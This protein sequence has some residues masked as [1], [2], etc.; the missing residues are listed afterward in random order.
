MGDTVLTSPN[1]LISA[2][3][4]L[5]ASALFER[6]VDLAP[7]QRDALLGEEQLEPA[8][9]EL[10]RKMF[11]AD[12]RVDDPFATPAVVWAAQL[13]LD[14]DAVDGLIGQ[15]IGGFRILSRLGQG[16]S[17]VVFA[18]ERDVAGAQQQ[19]A[20][21]LLQT[22]L[23]SAHAQRRFRRE[24]TILV[25]LTHPNIAHLIDAGVS[26]AGIPYIAMERIDGQTLIK[27]ARAHRLDLPSR[28]RLV[29]TAALAVDAAHRALVVHRDLKPDNILVDSEGRVKVLDFGIA[30]LIDD[31]EDP[32]QNPH[33][34]LTPGYA[35]PEQYRSGPLTTSVDVYALGVIAAE[36]AIDARLGPDASLPS[37]A[38]DATRRRWRALEADLATV[39]RT[40]LAEQPSQRYASAR[41]FAD[42]IERYLAREPIAAH[43]PSRTYRVRKFVSRHRVGLAVTAVMMLMLLGT[44]WSVL[45]QRN[46]AQQQAARADSMRDFMF[47]TFAEAEPSVPRD[48]P[49]TV[50]DAVRRAIA[51]NAEPEA[52]PA[53]RLELRLRLAQVLQRQG[54][55]DGA[56]AVFEAVRNAARERWGAGH[57][58]ALQAATLMVENSMARGEFALARSQLDG[59]PTTED[60]RH[61][62]ERLSLSAVLA[63]R[64]RELD[65]ALRDGEAALVL[66]RQIGDPELVRV[67]LNDWGVVLIAALRV[68]DAIKTYQELLTLNRARFGERHV[69]VGNVQAALS[70][71]YRRS[72]DLDRALVAARAA[73]EIDR[74]VYPGDDRHA[75]VNLNALMLVLRERGDLDEA[76]VVAREALRIN[77]AVLGDTHPDTSLARY[78]IGDLLMLRE[79][80]AQA[81]PLLGQSLAD[82][83]RAFGAQHWRTAAARAHYGFALGMSGSTDAGMAAMEQAI[84]DMQLLATADPD[85]LCSAIER[86]ARL[87]AHTGHHASALQWLDRLQASDTDAPPT[88]ACWLGNVELRRAAVALD[89]GRLIEANAAL[90]RAGAMIERVA[91]EVPM[92]AAEHAVLG[93]LLLQR[94]DPSAAIAA[95]SHAEVLLAKLRTIPP[96]L[97]DRVSAMR[98]VANMASPHKS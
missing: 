4:L 2:E 47:D 24:Q 55:L 74:T 77:V 6:Y 96:A 44:F 87:A 41:Y 98:A 52:D 50:L 54:D 63:S 40:A 66:A 39:L 84:A 42:D 78:G 30:K 26:V 22:G 49:V 57:W 14:A 72:G 64:T 46:L 79:D 17:S 35:A 69:K 45:T 75:A 70:R 86:R 28:L 76:L 37:T 38:A 23:Y 82:N 19:V 85:R 21:K 90:Q 25:G 91:T 13:Q 89:A 8:I 68:D 10:L 92:L 94:T 97:R 31:N 95:K 56:R 83:E 48:G 15:C 27:H 88:R 71:A 67:T 60:T 58:I 12:S 34:A 93:A 61:R 9:A 65:R 32:T 59:L 3:V 11:A 1:D 53:V 36:L 20:L 5:R 29:V 81:V 7:M 80:Y 51:S 62:L 18:A 43:P 73:V 16:G 33:I